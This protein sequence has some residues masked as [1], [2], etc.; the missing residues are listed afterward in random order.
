MNLPRRAIADIAGG[1]PFFARAIETDSQAGNLELVAREEADATCVD[2]VTFAYVVR[3]RPNVAA[4]LRVLA[5]TPRSPTI[6]F[7]TSSATP[8]ATA[9]RLRRAL[10]EVASAP[11]WANVRAGLLL[12][13]VVPAEAADYECLLEYEQQAVTLGYPVL[14]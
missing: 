9:E 5:P 6:P 13:S 11:G 2:N 7:V 4:Q 8:P 12:R 3:H 10:A 14:C 1:S